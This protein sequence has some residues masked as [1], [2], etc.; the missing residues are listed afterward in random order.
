M[1]LRGEK[2]LE[3]P[4]SLLFWLH[5]CLMR[6][7]HW[8]VF[9]IYIIFT[10]SQNFLTFSQLL[11]E[12]WSQNI[13]NN[14]SKERFVLRFVHSVVS[15]L[16]TYHFALRNTFRTQCNTT[17]DNNHFCPFIRP[18]KIIYPLLLTI[19]RIMTWD[20]DPSNHSIDFLCL[21]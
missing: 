1:C 12:K 20:D 21:D 14:E 5:W 2:R 15:C 4:N 13:I 16:M 8:Y 7:F 19:I 9:H 17:F 10:L 6:C 3:S 11:V 18:S